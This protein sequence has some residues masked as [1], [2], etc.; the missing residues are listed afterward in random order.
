MAS[1][2]AYATCEGIYRDNVSIARCCQNDKAEIHQGAGRLWWSGIGGNSSERGH[3]KV[4]DDPV[5]GGRD[6]SK[7]QIQDDRAQHAVCGDGTGSEHRAADNKANDK[8]NQ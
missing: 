6:Y 2:L 7:V 3:M 5:N 4:P 1:R 8:R